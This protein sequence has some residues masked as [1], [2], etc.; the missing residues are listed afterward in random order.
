M[1]TLTLLLCSL[2]GS[3]SL[4]YGKPLFLTGPEALVSSNGSVVEGSV[5][6]IYCTVEDN[7]A[8]TFT[9]TLNG[10]S[11]LNDPP[12]IRIREDNFPERSA[13]SLTDDSTSVLTVDNFR[14]SD[15]GVYQ[16]TATSGATSGN[17]AAVR[18]TAVSSTGDGTL[19]LTDQP[20]LNEPIDYFASLNDNRT[21]IALGGTVDGSLLICTAGHQGDGV[22][23]YAAPSVVWVR[24]GQV[25]NDTDSRI[26]ITLTTLV[27]GQVTSSL[28]ITNFGLSDA[29]VYQCVFTDDSDGGEVITSIPSQLD[30]GT[31]IRIERVSPEVII[32]RPPEKLVIETRVSGE[33]KVL[34]WRKGTINTFIPGQ[35]RPQEFPKYFET[36]VRDKTTADDEGFYIVQPQLK[37]GTTQTHT[38]TPTGGVDFGVIAPVDANT[39][40]LSISTV[41]IPEGSSADISCRSVGAPV[42]SIT[43][44]VNN[45]TT[46]FEQTDTETPFVATLTGTIGN[47]GV[48]VTPGSVDSSLHIVSATYPDHDGVYTCIGANSEDRTVASSSS[49]VTV[50][51]NVIPVVEISAT[52][53]MVAFGDDVTITCSVQKGNPSNYLYVI[54]NVNTTST[55]IGPTRILTGIEAADFGIYRCDVTNNAGTGSAAIKIQIVDCGPPIVP[56]HGRVHLPSGTTPGNVVYYFCDECSTIRGVSHIQYCGTDGVWLLPAPTCRIRNECGLLTSPVNGHVEMSA[57]S[58]CGSIADY[59]CI[60][61]YELRGVVSRVCQVSGVWN[62][63][64]PSCERVDCGPLESPINGSVNTS[65]GTLFMSEAIY[66]CNNGYFISDARHRTCGAY[67]QW[68]RNEPS[69]IPVNC[70]YPWEIAN[71][72]VRYSGTTFNH[73]ATYS[74]DY[75]YMLHGF[76]TRTCN[77][78]GAWQPFEPFCQIV[79]C[80]PLPNPTNGMVDLSSRTVFTSI[81]TFTCDTGYTLNGSSFRQCLADGVWSPAEPTCTA[82]DCGALEHPI[83]GSVNVSYGTKFGNEAVYSCSDGYILIGQKKH[84]CTENGTWS[85]K[86]DRICDPVDCGPP[87]GPT[88]GR[89]DTSSGTTFMSAVVYSCSTGYNLY[90][91]RSRVCQANGLWS[92]TPPSC[93]IVDCGPLDNPLNGLVNTLSGTTYNSVAVYSCNEGHQLTERGLLTCMVNGQW[94][95]LTPTCDPLDCGNIEA[96]KNGDVVTSL[97]TIFNSSAKFSCGSGFNLTGCSSAQCLSNGSWSCYP[98]HCADN[99]LIQLKFGPTVHCVSWTEGM[100]ELMY[101]TM[102]SSIVKAIQSQGSVIPKEN[103]QPGYFSCYHSTTETTYRTT[104]TGTKSLSAVKYTDLIRQW[105]ESGVTTRVQWYVIKIKK[106]CPVI[107]A[108]MYEDE[109]E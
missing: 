73:K 45:Q 75:G 52:K 8:A 93:K 100:V 35:M 48:D 46:N 37:P 41:V 51:I 5:I 43:W 12:H 24:S 62:G 103:V 58:E 68:N 18:L 29:G 19:M 30:T 108:S 96:P 14:A 17:G 107:I 7:T 74:C 104:I 56:R 109:C 78:N 64:M 28:T 69:C 57:G 34:F 54:T 16:C 70:G 25:V 71:G 76:K 83:Y 97:G 81:A 4:V 20:S 98:P 27:N 88:N 49:F 90:G 72:V 105:V 15:N 106:A 13:S 2:L 6:Q 85:P 11:L 21:G 94:S 32:L 87:S 92:S 59:N 42:P 33:Y 36:F 44:E 47:R 26:T 67:G 80:G 84:T 39:T 101:K 10:S 65:L 91:T 82:V 60:V 86:I 40:S 89:V 31:T 9:W 38:I 1:A 53:I 55:T 99:S 66:Y 77:A 95:S 61:G 79:D 63:T 50:Q 22:G 23:N 102:Q 3:V